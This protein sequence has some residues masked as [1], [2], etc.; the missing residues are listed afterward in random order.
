MCFF[1]ITNKPIVINSLIIA[2]CGVMKLITKHNNEKEAVLSAIISI[3]AGMH[4]ARYVQK[5]C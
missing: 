4:L 2:S 3:E 5:M 1:L